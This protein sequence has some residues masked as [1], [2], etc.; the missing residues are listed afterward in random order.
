MPTVSSCRLKHMYASLYGLDL[1][2][3]YIKYGIPGDDGLAQLLGP[4][5]VSTEVFQRPRLG[6]RIPGFVLRS[7]STKQDLL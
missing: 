1:A 7:A 5:Q 2:H 6:C 4:L 3:L